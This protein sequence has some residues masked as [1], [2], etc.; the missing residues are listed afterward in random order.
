LDETCLWLVVMSQA[1]KC[2]QVLKDFLL[3]RL[4]HLTALNQS[5]HAKVELAF[6]DLFDHAEVANLKELQGQQAIGKEPMAQGKQ[7]DGLGRVGR[8]VRLLAWHRHG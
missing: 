2:S 3:V 1:G 4:G 6:D 5:N 7:G 8:S